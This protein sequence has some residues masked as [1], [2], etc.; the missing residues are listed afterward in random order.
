[1]IVAFS[2]SSPVVS[3]A[4]ISSDGGVIGVRQRHAPMAASGAAMNMLEELLAECGRSLDEATGFAADLGPGSFTGVR[5]G[6]TLAKTLAYAHGTPTY[7]LDS[8]DLVSSADV[9]V[10]PSKKGEFFVRQPN[11]VHVRTAEL[12]SS[13]FVGYGHGRDENVYP[14]AAAFAPHVARLKS[15]PPEELVPA[16]LIEPSI[17]TPKKPYPV[18]P[19]G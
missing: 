3:V 16:Y 2:T 8:F 19:N 12:P 14:S 6:V 4:L 1:V 17:S 13:P 9:V 15:C 18:T 5:V 7:G 11:S 10:L